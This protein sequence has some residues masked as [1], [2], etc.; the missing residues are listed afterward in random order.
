MLFRTLIV[1]VSIALIGALVI[2]SIHNDQK[3]QEF[4]NKHSCNVIESTE[5][6]YISTP[7]YN[8]ATKSWI[9]QQTYYPG[10]KVYKCSDGKE[11]T[12]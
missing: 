7:V 3:W 12:R 9:V 11:Y 5:G 6:Y 10:H 8:S 2:Y 4:S 1:I